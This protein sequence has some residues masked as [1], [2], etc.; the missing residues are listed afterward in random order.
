MPMKPSIC[1]G[2]RRRSFVRSASERS[3][4]DR[5]SVICADDSGGESCPAPVICRPRRRTT[6]VMIA[7]KTNQSLRAP[8]AGVQA[9]LNGRVWS[10]ALAGE[11][12]SWPMEF[13]TLVRIGYARDC[14]FGEGDE[15]NKGRQ[16]V[17]WTVVRP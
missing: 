10:L 15:R 11:A 7:T 5:I 16:G 2:L 17:L 3:G 8:L 9:R 13:S 4:L 14:R 12:R 1:S 6:L